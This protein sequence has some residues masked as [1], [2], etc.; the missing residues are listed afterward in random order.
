MKTNRFIRECR[1]SILLIPAMTLLLLFFVVPVLLTIFFSF[2]NMALTGATA[3]NYDI[4]GLSNYIRLF[5]DN[6]ALSVIK[7]TLFF[8]AGSLLVGPC[9]LCGWVMPEIVVS[10]C[11]LAFFDMEGTANTILKAIHLPVISWIFGFPMLTVILANI[12]HGTAFSMLNFQSALDHV[13][14]DMEEAARVDGANRFQVLWHLLIPCMKQTIGMNTMLNTFS[15]LGVFGLIWAMTGGGPGNKTTTLS[16][17]MYNA[18]MKNFQLGKGTAIGILILLLGG[19]CSIGYSFLFY[20]REK[21][22]RGNFGKVKTT[23]AERREG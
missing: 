9:I 2:T 14:R 7:N 18:G 17:Y 15:T 8:L 5:K 22:S 12:W 23:L 13:P 4:V 1:Q 20:E 6:V 10:L 21:K 19:V 11:M 3:K 16:I